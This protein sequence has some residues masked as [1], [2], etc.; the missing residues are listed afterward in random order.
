MANLFYACKTLWFEHE[1]LNMLRH[2]YTFHTDML[3]YFR[4]N[5][6]KDSKEI[7]R[8]HSSN[9]ITLHVSMLTVGTS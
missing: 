8:T 6:L 5:M 4:H 3:K 2:I 9:E 7:R 1:D